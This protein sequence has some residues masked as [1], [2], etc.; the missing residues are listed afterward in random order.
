MMV[1]YFSVNFDI[2]AMT[3]MRSLSFSM[4]SGVCGMHFGPSIM[5]EIWGQ[6]LC[7]DFVI[8]ILLDSI[9]NASGSSRLDVVMEYL[10]RAARMKFIFGDG[11]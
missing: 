10:K 4:N 6:E 8:I 2:C 1:I 9:V 5:T 7:P 3:F 11:S